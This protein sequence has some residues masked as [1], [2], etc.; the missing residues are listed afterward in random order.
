[1]T[2]ATSNKALAVQD[3]PRVIIAGFADGNAFNLLQRIASM[4]AASDLV[5]TAYRG[6]VANCALVVNMAKRLECDPL[7]AMQ[8]LHIIQGRPSWSAPFLIATVNTCGKF[9]ELDFE[10]AGKE[11]TDEY[12]C[13]AVATRL[14][15]KK[16][17]CGSWVSVLLAKKEGW[18]G[19]TGSKWPN[20]TEQ[21]LRYRAAAF[22]VR[23]FAPEL[24]L[25]LLTE[26]EQNDIVDL[27]LNEGKIV[28]PTTVLAE[29][30][31]NFQQDSAVDISPA[32]ASVCAGEDDSADDALVS[33]HDRAPPLEACED[34]APA[35]EMQAQPVDPLDLAFKAGRACALACGTRELPKELRYKSRSTEAQAWIKGY[36]EAKE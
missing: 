29:T 8:N 7:M 13:R 1:M 16:R 17:L 35:D 2:D 9:S 26:D 36:D 27:P 34:T 6:K 23:A 24:S 30:A 11:T 25:G 14:S 4:F 18:W 22:W 31:P 15:T 28:H 19:R 33:S 10:F 32:D 5:P 21:M 20:M 3:E 12:R